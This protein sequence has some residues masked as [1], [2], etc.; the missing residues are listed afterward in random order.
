M[1]PL[2]ILDVHS[3]Y[4]APHKHMR[5]WRLSLHCFVMWMAFWIC[6]FN[7][8]VYCVICTRQMTHSSCWG[9]RVNKEIGV[10][11]AKVLHSKKDW[12]PVYSGRCFLVCLKNLCECEDQKTPGNVKCSK[13]G[14]PQTL[15]SWKIQQ[16]EEPKYFQFMHFLLLA[17]YTLCVY[18]WTREKKK[19]NK[20]VETPQ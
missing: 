20:K 11:V 17:L 9:M 8:S 12:P 5:A 16:Y 4:S 14:W 2:A 13:L 3:G 1:S 6:P 18:S 7:Q 10:K 19:R 15:H